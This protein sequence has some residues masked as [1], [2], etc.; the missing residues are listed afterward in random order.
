MWAGCGWGL[1]L[2]AIDELK[3][4][5]VVELELKLKLHTEPY[6]QMYFD[7][8]VYARMFPLTSLCVGHGFPL[9]AFVWIM[10]SPCKPL[11]VSCFLHAFSPTTHARAYASDVA[12]SGTEVFELAS[13]FDL[14]LAKDGAAA[15]V[16]ASSRQSDCAERGLPSAPTGPHHA[17]GFRPS[18]YTA[19]E[20]RLDDLPLLY[21]EAP[22]GKSLERDLRLQ[23]ARRCLQRAGAGGRGRGRACGAC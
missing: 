7:L 21:R 20:E 13:G 5:C 3:L 17:Y 19:H 14:V 12:I 18:L 10:I 6:I 15:V 2:E 23:G 4:S 1:E 16:G 8:S 11:C 22:T 9:Q